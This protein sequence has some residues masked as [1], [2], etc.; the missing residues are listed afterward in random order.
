YGW[1]AE[2]PDLSVRADRLWQRLAG[3]ATVGLA[4]TA[5]ACEAGTMQAD[6]Q[7][8]IERAG[9]HSPFLEL[10]L[11]RQPALTALLERGEGEEALAAARDAGADAP[12][13]ATALRRER[14]ALA[15]A[16]AIGDLAGA[17]ALERV[18]AEL[19]AFADRALDRA[20]ADA[21]TRRVPDSVPDGF[22]AI[23]LGKLG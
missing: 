23:A 11:R 9:R 5:R 3:A 13:V 20:I 17:F 2:H 21:I 8:A 22:A 16:L 18:M 15:A 12:D 1:K 4:L 19:S 6:W 7:A 14:L 10:A